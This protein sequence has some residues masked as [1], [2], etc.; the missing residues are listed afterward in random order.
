[1]VTVI[2]ILGQH[3]LGHHTPISVHKKGCLS[4]ESNKWTILTALK[5]KPLNIKQIETVSNMLDCTTRLIPA[6]SHK[7]QNGT[8]WHPECLFLFLGTLWRFLA[9]ASQ[10]TLC[11]KR[12][13]TQRLGFCFFFVCK[14][15]GRNTSY[16]V[17]PPHGIYSTL[18]MAFQRIHQFLSTSKTAR[19]RPFPDDPTL[20]Q[21]LAI[22]RRL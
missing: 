5:Y 3:I 22:P 4:F 20:G 11:P 19:R 6:R 9:S 7:T 13:L 16:T 14:N 12:P 1:M 8:R 2:Q 21:S 15:G 10:M 17:C 18:L